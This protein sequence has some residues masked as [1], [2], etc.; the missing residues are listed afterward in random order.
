MSNTLFRIHF[1]GSELPIDIPAAN[2]TEARK[3]AVKA[4]PD[5]LIKKIKVVKG[6]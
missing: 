1:H 5:A 4:R 2:P 3:A 6:D